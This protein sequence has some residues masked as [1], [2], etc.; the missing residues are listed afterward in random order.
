MS[1]VKGG[2]LAKFES[3]KDLIPSH[4]VNTHQATYLAKKLKDVIGVHNNTI[5]HHRCI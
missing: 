1:V 5:L 2:F 4:V 3:G